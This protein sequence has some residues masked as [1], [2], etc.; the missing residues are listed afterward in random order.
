VLASI[1]GPVAMVDCNI[2]A[3][4][5]RR[6]WANALQ[7]HV[8][9]S[10]ARPRAAWIEFRCDEAVRDSV[11]MAMRTG[12]TLLTSAARYWRAV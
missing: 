11:N 8:A 5:H 4:S 9:T 12:G 10:R 7:L 2:V 6:S 3:P 1:A